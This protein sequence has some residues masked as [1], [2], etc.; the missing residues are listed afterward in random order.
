[1]LPGMARSRHSINNLDERDADPHARDHQVD[2]LRPSDQDADRSSHGSRR[3]R[4]AKG[5]GVEVSDRGRLAERSSRRPQD[6]VPDR[7][8]D[9]GMP[10]MPWTAPG[11]MG[12][13]PAPAET[14]AEAGHRA[15]ALPA[16]DMTAQL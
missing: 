3:A 2:D 11:A 14:E 13:G 7:P 6:D 10:G 16:P 12:G 4:I 15:A 5:S 9:G 1:M 8:R